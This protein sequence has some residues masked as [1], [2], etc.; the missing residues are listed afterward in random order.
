MLYEVITDIKELDPEDNA[1]PDVTGGYILA[2]DR[3]EK[4]A[5]EGFTFNVPDPD[6][7]ATN[8]QM[9]I[10]YVSPKP[11]AITLE[12]KAYINNYLR[13]F[14]NALTDNDSATDYTTYISVKS[15]ID[16]Q[17]LVELSMNIDGLLYSTY[18][19]KDR[20]GLV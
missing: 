2:V 13:D 10:L 9:N 8:E 5:A 20:D 19:Y 18:M 17:I 15:F 11:D 1:E 7:P 16:Q 14:T 3:D 6:A 4:V 12:Q